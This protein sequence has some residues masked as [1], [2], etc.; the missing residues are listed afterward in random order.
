MGPLVGEPPSRTRRPTRHCRPADC[1]LPARSCVSLSHE[2]TNVLRAC[3]GACLKIAITALLVCLG[4][5][6]SSAFADAPS[7]TAFVDVNVLPMSDDRVLRG[8]T[9]VIRDQTIVAI[10]PVSTTSVPVDARRVEGRGRAFLLPGLADMHTH[11][12]DEEDLS[13]F[14]ANGV[15]TILHM[16]ISPDHMVLSANRHIEQ[17]QAV[18]PRIFFAKLIDGTRDSEQFFVATPEQAAHAVDLAKTNGYDFIKVYNGLTAS[19]FAA[20]VE[21]ARRAGLPVIGHGV[22]GV[23]LPRQL[24]EGQVMVAHAEEFLY[25][26]F[27]GQADVVQIPGIAAEVARSGAFVTPNLSLFRVLSEQWGKPAVAEAYVRDPRARLISPSLRLRWL[28]HNSY[29]HRTGSIEG[30]LPFL[31]QLTKAMADAG[32][33]L[34]AGTD[35][36]L[37]GM[38]PGYSVHDDIRAL[39]DAGLSP[40][41]A[42]TAATRTPGD[43][44]AKHVPASARFGTVEI[45]KRADLVLADSNPLDNVAALRSPL[46]VMTGGRWYGAVDIQSLL[47]RQRAMYDAVSGGAP[48][49]TSTRR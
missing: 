1:N 39:I 36:P 25:T 34:L 7:A 14:I 20:V 6:S 42:L 16:G 32:V 40:Y 15:T 35:S 46:G 22:R 38:F 2:C 41:Q 19:Q 23:G 45:G 29:T 9:V 26:A 33:P 21:Q 4:L 28:A 18:G 43:F 5:G 3:V 30:I 12:N 31:Q 49:T 10:G 11:V 47:A 37:P 27:H 13:L 17:G 48:E 8:R 24:F 44:V